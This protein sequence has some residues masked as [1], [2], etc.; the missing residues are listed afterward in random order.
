M[1]VVEKLAEH[2]DKSVTFVKCNLSSP[3]LSVDD[4][5]KKLGGNA[6]RSVPTFVFVTRGKE[7]SRIVGSLDFNSFKQQVVTNCKV[8]A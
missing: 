1:P 5:I 6:V 7:T 3:D 4:M 8:A 2:F